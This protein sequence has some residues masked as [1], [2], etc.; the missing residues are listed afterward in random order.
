[1]RG[2][3]EE[4]YADALEVDPSGREEFLAGACGGDASLRAEVEALLRDAE[5]ADT[6]F[7]QLTRGAPGAPG[8]GIP[9][10]RAGTQIGPYRLVSLLGRGGFGSVWLAEQERPIRRRVA[11]KLI[12]RGMDSEEVLARF[13]AEQQ[14]LALMDHPNI[15]RVFEAGTTPDGRPFFAMEM[16]EGETITRFCDGHNLSIPERLRLFLQVC[17]AVN[18]AH[19][20]G[21]IHRDLKP[22]NILVALA[23]GEPV[24]KVIDFGI[25]KAIEGSIAGGIDVTRAE[26]FV[27]TPAYMSPE[28]A[29]GDRSGIDTRTDVYSLGVIL[30]E[31]LVGTAPF[32][33]KT[34]AAAGREEIRRIIREEEPA[35]PS[36]KLLDLPEAERTRVAAARKAVADNLPRLVGSELDWIAMKAI[37]KSKDRRYETAD[38]LGKDVQRYLDNEPVSARPPSAA[39]LLGKMA[40]RHRALLGAVAVIAAILVA[41]TATSV[42]LA[43][44]ARE[45]ERLADARLAQALAEQAARESAQRDAEAVSDFIVEVFRRPDPEVDGRT[46]TVARALDTASQKLRSGLSD[47][48]VRLALIQEALAKTYAGLG[49]YPESLELR[50]KVLETRRSALGT[51]NPATLAAMHDL[52]SML[53]ALG[54]YQ[55]ARDLGEEELAVRRRLG[56]GDDEVSLEAAAMLAAN[57]FRGGDHGK[58][59]AAQ[60]DLLGRLTAAHGAS[61]PRSSRAARVLADYYRQTGDDKSAD[62]I[63][64]S[65]KKDDG[66]RSAPVTDSEHHAKVNKRLEDMEAQLA[67]IREA[68]GPQSAET[69]AFMSGLATAYYGSTHRGEAIRTQQ[70]LVALLREKLGDEHPETTAAEE[71]LA[72]YLWRHNRMG[73]AVE[74]KKKLIE[75]RSKI[76][77]P[78]HE[79]TLT[80][81]ADLAGNLQVGDGKSSEAQAMLEE[82]V[83]LMRKVLGASDRRTLNAISNLAR[84]YATAGRTR[85]AMDLLAECA[86]QMPDDTFV[87]LLLANLQ[88]WAGLDDDYN[89][90]RRWMIDYAVARRGGMRNRPDILERAILIACLAPLE[91]PDQGSELL[92]TLARCDEIR[93]AG[94]RPKIF[95]PAPAW[96]G[97]AAGMLHYRAG[98][99]EKADAAL[100]ETLRLLEGC[101]TWE[102]TPAN[103]AGVNLYRAMSM[104][105]QGKDGEA[106]QLYME[107]SKAIISPQ[108]A[109]QPLL[110]NWDAQGTPLIA[111]LAHREAKAIFEQAPPNPANPAAAA[112]VP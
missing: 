12:K 57:Y 95:E 81:R 71:T 49:L 42:W 83:P 65:T 59:I 87:N 60:K 46:V 27:G 43:V 37:E 66:A 22:S 75:R 70:E 24:A 5:G 79:E 110:G 35:R 107:A 88:L 3:A 99:Y 32:D 106:R 23:D 104:L 36:T 78:E 21:V 34:L 58:A 100:S 25:V 63:E 98:D 53:V 52:I 112:G 74:L 89:K 13:R 40:R 30:Y 15:A 109:E 90:T 69:L 94:G 44:R 19:Q 17:A 1:M 45:A 41:A 111:R 64:R 18:H 108:S 28:Q 51:D 33:E 82:C 4:I 38:A 26:Q 14:A 80:A 102:N 54:Y 2:G 6:F 105:K 62:E 92:A 67:D 76:F 101:A 10:D 77:G 72:F 9:A 97:L 91:N 16:V 48:P 11:L 103:R 96:R 86:P 73:E 61:D 68:K 7:D 84:C 39:Y 93:A 20:K 31:L 29:G 85:E 56:G 47:Q 55:E 8:G 50:K